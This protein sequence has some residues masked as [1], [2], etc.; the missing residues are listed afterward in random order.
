MFKNHCKTAWR[1]LVKNPVFSAIN[2]MGLAIGLTVCMLI[3]VYFEHEK[4]Y[5]SFH[6][7]AERICW[8]QSKLKFGN[9]SVFIPAIS[10][11]SG[12]MVKHG[13]PLVEDYMRLK[14]QGKNTL[15]QN[16][17][18]ASLKF[19]E[20]QF[21]FADKDFF[22]FFSFSLLKGS[23][24]TVLNKPFT[25][26]LSSK[27][28]ARY[29]GSE[30]PVGK[31][32]KYNDKYSFTV[33]GVA[34][35]V[36]SNSSINFD[37]VASMASIGS[38]DE[39]KN[40]L[41]ADNIDVGSFTTYFLVKNKGD[42]K[43]LAASINKLAQTGSKGDQNNTTF[44][45]TALTKTH[46]DFNETSES[47]I[48]YLSLFPFVA[49]LILL[50]ALINYMSLAT[51]R[52]AT[53]AKEIGVRKTM[54]AS[55]KSI[56]VQFFI[57]SALYTS[58]SF[59]L[60]YSL[61]VLI[62]PPFFNFLGIDV[63]ASFLQNSGILLS[64]AALYITTIILAAA[65]PSV[66]LSAYKPIMVLYGRLTRQTGALSVRKF[67]TVF[68]FT[69]SVGLIICGI[70][71]D[72]QM[73]FFKHF[74]TGINRQNVIMVPF[75]TSIGKH[76]G[77]FKKDVQ[78]IAAIKQVS[79]AHYPMYKGYDIF[80]VTPKG[81]QQLVTLP[82]F[83]V[84][85]NF[86]PMLGLQWK[87][88]PDDPL[89]YNKKGMAVLNEAA[90][91]KLGLKNAPLHEKVDGQFEVAAVVKN[92]NFASLQNKIEALALFVS[93]DNDTASA[94]G[95]AGGCLFAKLQPNADEGQVIQLIKAAYEKYDRQ[96]PFEYSFMDDAYDAMYKAEDK[97]LKIFS[98]FTVFTI[99]IASLGLLGLT[100]FMAV[101]RTKEV[102]IRKVLGASVAGIAVLLSKE[103][104]QL[105]LIAILI[106]SPLAWWAMHLW[107]QGFAY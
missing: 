56:A 71:I 44:M 49:G 65:Y 77:A 35:K 43:Q 21:Y 25:V 64:F 32:I 7:N 103:F 16:P 26:V 38:I 3:M 84:D 82:A 72:R 61:C 104:M 19:T 90:V 5:D 50:L 10:F 105:V 101:Q 59:V 85:E 40:N 23:P 100:A 52:S 22:N 1:N 95:K 29:F 96:K 107:L 58:I 13:S 92:F 91:E 27:A 9:D 86:I 34:A 28:A 93:H 102:G 2:I 17:Q 11:V 79:T 75:A 97:M 94:W 99:L 48:K 66:L 106:A 98:V 73:Y 20:D 76:Y 83:S 89:Y 62:Q 6:K 39:E 8:V 24:K 46:L 4:S 57:E 51:A 37:F 15:V 14:H 74:N 69:I 55:R 54:G 41:K 68:Q 45:V 78:S 47:N 53:R 36:P 88:H 67:F 81:G 30:N 31:T 18:S 87:T 33:T 63:D 12:P 60:A 80:M 42:E 70:V